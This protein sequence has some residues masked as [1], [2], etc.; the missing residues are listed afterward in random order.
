MHTTSSSRLYQEPHAT[1]MECSQ[2]E[3]P[4]SGVSPLATP[5]PL[6]IKRE[7]PTYPPNKLVGRLNGKRMKMTHDSNWCVAEISLNAPLKTQERSTLP[8][9]PFMCYMPSPLSSS[10]HVPHWFLTELQS[11]C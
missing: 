1:S 11:R 8:C 3:G 7:Q 10:H 4:G 9:H 2:V 6:P 5:L